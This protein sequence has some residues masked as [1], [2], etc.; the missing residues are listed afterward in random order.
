M[1]TNTTRYY[2]QIPIQNTPTH[3]LENPPRPPR[4]VT[5]CFILFRLEGGGATHGFVPQRPAPD[6]MRAIPPLRPQDVEIPGASEKAP[7]AAD[8]L[9]LARQWRGAGICLPSTRLR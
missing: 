5:S 2:M 4:G 7:Q 1:N 8:A 6:G 9:L 3:T